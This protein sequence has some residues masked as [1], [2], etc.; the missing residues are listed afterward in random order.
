MEVPWYVWC[1]ALMVLMTIAYVMVVNCGRDEP[2]MPVPRVRWS[3]GPASVD[4]VPSPSPAPLP[5]DL[6][7]LYSERDKLDRM[8]YQ[9]VMPDHPFEERS[10]V[11]TQIGNRRHVVPKAVADELLRLWRVEID[12]K[13]SGHRTQDTGPS[14]SPSPPGGEPA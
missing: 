1:M 5:V 9:A 4:Y 7:R 14:P 8:I 11:V 6:E 13:K 2:G 12:F 3:N 10:A